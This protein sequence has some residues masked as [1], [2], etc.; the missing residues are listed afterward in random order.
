[1]NWKQVQS[2]SIKMICSSVA[3]FRFYPGSNP[4]RGLSV[5]PGGKNDACLLFV[6]HTTKTIHHHH[7]HL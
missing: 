5:V 1:M 3:E 2:E 6:N 4:A 7:H